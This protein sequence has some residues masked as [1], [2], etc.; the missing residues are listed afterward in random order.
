GWRASS[1]STPASSGGT[2]AAGSPGGASPSQPARSAASSISPAPALSRPLV[3]AAPEDDGDPGTASTSRPRSSARSAVIRAPLRARASTTS[4]VSA[5]AAIS[6]FR[7][8]NRQGAG[9]V[10]GGYSDTTTPHSST[11]ANSPALV[12]G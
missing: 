1:A 5:R 10:P 8:G 6:R 3:P 2:V 7:A 11:R 4:R 9:G 12:R